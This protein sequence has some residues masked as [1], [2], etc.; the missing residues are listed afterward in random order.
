MRPHNNFASGRMSSVLLDGTLIALSSVTTAILF[1]WLL[2]YSSYGLNPSDEGFWLN[3][4]ADPFAYSI[5]IPPNF[6]ALSITGHTSG[7]AATLQCFASR[8]SRLQWR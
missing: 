3:S 5:K 6:L 7:R 1:V 2:Y 4:M 8:T